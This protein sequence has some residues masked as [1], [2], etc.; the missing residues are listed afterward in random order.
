LKAKNCF[1]AWKL[2]P[3]LSIAANNIRYLKK[4]MEIFLKLSDFFK[5]FKTKIS[6][7]NK[8]KFSLANN[9]NFSIDNNMVEKA[10]NMV[11]SHGDKKLKINMKEVLEKYEQYL[12]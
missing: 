8:I 6:K 11:E 2:V 4:F 1:H 7:A 3:T 12:K 9:M 10:N 5:E